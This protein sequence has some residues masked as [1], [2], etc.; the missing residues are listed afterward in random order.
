MILLKNTDAIIFDFGGVLI[1]IDYQATIDAFKNLGIGDFDQL[2][3]QASQSDLFD[4]IETGK[5]SAQRFINGL[6]D[7][8]PKGTTPNQVIQAWN[9][10]ILDVPSSTVELLES[11]QGKYR[12]FML[13]N[14]NSIHLDYALLQW[15]KTSSKLPADLF[16][17]VYLSYEM[18]M[19]KPNP[20]IFEFVCTEQKLDFERTLFIDD[21]IQHIEGA[22]SIGLKTTLIAPDYS[23]GSIFS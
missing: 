5:I 17:K 11:L 13:S 12:L 16:E 19:R 23:L 14:T 10:M 4:A 3:S 20:E 22:A 6:L 1:N 2:Y 18:G 7:F 21:S 9:A 8:L 15:K